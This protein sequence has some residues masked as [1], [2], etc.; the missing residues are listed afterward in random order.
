MDALGHCLMIHSLQLLISAEKSESAVVLP[1]N[2]KKLANSSNFFKNGENFSK[3]MQLVTKYSKYEKE[4]IELSF[5]SFG[6]IWKTKLRN[7]AIFSLLAIETLKKY[8][9]SIFKISF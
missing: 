6:H 3:K 5:H 2:T 1:I 4:N 9:I 8:S 7:R